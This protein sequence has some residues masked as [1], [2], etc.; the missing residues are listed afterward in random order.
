[1][2]VTVAVINSSDDTVEM[3]RL[4][5][6]RAGFNTAT[7]HISD[8][9]KGATDFLQFMNQHDPDIVI[10]D[11]GHPYKENCTFLQLLLNT[12]VGKRTKFLLTTTNRALLQKAAGPDIEAFE[13]SEKPYDL[14]DL[15]QLVKRTL[16]IEAA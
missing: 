10:Y 6:E 11:V 4:M 5:M 15:V 16:G 1:M 13:L 9:K 2:A 8:I 14:N 3:V 7:G 12:E